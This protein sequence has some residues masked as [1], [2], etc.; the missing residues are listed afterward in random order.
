M[1]PKHSLCYEIGA[2]VDL[3]SWPAIEVLK[4]NNNA[5]ENMERGIHMWEEEEK[6]RLTYLHNESRTTCKALSQK[7]E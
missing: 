5:K 7:I 4:L 3:E 6:Q 2:N 1:Q